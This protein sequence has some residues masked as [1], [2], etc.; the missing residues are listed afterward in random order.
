MPTPAYMTIEGETQGDITE[1]A[2]SEESIGNDFQEEHADEFLV[3]AFE[4]NISVPVN[5]QS[6]QPSGQR[7]HKSMIVTKVFDKCSPLLYTALCTGERLPEC[8]IK[9]FR[10]SSEGKEE[11]YFTTKLSDATIVSIESAMPN[12]QDPAHEHF[13]HLEKIAL[14]YRKIEWEHEVA[15]TAG[16]DDWRAKGAE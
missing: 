4:H 6:G 12:C 10:T 3:Q 13:T 8:E 11:H 7:V 9:W 5:P 16:A 14:R 15:G 2:N 1:G